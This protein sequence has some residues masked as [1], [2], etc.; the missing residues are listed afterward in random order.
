M[1]NTIKFLAA[2]LLVTTLLSGCIWPWW[3]EGGRGGHHGGGHY[4]HR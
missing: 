3:E 1:K 2:T 4:D